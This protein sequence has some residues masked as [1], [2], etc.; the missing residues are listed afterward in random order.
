MSRRPK[1]RSANRA[2]IVPSSIGHAPPS[3]T[4]HTSQRATVSQNV[5]RR[6]LTHRYTRQGRPRISGAAPHALSAS[7]VV[8]L[9]L[10]DRSGSPRTHAGSTFEHG[11][12]RDRER[13]PREDP[14]RV[15]APH[16]VGL[17]VDHGRT[18][19]RRPPCMPPWLLDRLDL[20]RRCP[21]GERSPPMSR[22]RSCP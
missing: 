18:I 10:C 7:Q 5:S 6:L 2:Q 20:E 21:T 12:L 4:P 19:R 3:P 22:Q 16:Q 1:H 15:G 13:S 9:R 8:A 11:H 17:D 14:G